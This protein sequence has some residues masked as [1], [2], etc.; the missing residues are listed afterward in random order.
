L[1]DSGT[2]I[3]E[4]SKI[5]QNAKMFKDKKGKFAKPKLIMK[6]KVTSASINMVDVHV[7]TRN[8]ANEE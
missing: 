5:W 4:L 1:W 6:V 2:Q 8:K 3:Y 7:T